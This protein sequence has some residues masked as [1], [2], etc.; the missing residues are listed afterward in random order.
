VSRLVPLNV[1]AFIGA[2]GNGLSV[3]EDLARRFLPVFI[4]PQCEDAEA[5]PFKDG[6]AGFLAGV[7]RDRAQLLSACLT[8]WRYGR[9]NKLPAGLPLGNFEDWAG[10]CRDPLLALGCADPVQRMLATKANDPKR[11][12]IVELFEAWWNAHHGD[13][14]K[15]SALHEAVLAILNP[16]GRGRQYVAQRLLQLVGTRGAG[17]VLTYQPPAGAKTGGTYALKATTNPVQE[18][19]SNSSNS[20]T[21]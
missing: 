16:Q 3:G 2:T 9:Q 4:E 8:I 18:E 11:R 7:R 5:R 17:F 20:S 12:F 15:A 13:A 21:P 14:V 19:A 1:S 6:A 10:W